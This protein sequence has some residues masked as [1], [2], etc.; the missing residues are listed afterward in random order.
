[1]SNRSTIAG[2][3]KQT[4][5]FQWSSDDRS[6]RNQPTARLIGTGSQWIAEDNRFDGSTHGSALPNNFALEPWGKNMVNSTGHNGDS[7]MPE[8]GDGRIN[9]ISSMRFSN[10][11][12]H[13][14]SMDRSFMDQ[15]ISREQFH[16]LP[17]Q[18][19]QLIFQVR[20]QIAE[21]TY[22]TE[23]KFQLAFDELL[24]DVLE[25]EDDFWGDR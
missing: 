5:N 3:G 1:M 13:T 15:N 21:G 7:I 2:E 16:H 20:R 17:E 23:E 6:L 9:R 14:T 4:P 8:F 22:D 11:N 12:W 19:R 10:F 24:R 25:D 18:R